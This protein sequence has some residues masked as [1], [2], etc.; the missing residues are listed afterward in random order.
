[1]VF[2]VIMYGWESEVK[3][4]VANSWPTLCN[5]MDCR[6]PGSSVHGIFQARILEW[7]AI[8]FSRRSSW[9]RDWTQVSCIVG[10]CFTIWATREVPGWESWAIKNAEHQRINAFKLWCWRRLLRVSWTA[11]RSNQ[12]ILRKSTLNIHWKDWC[13]S[14]SSSTLATCCKG[15]IHCKRPSCW[16]KLRAGGEGGNRGWDGWMT[17]STQWT[18]IWANSGR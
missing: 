10:R 16:E 9:P 7:V 15:Q 14:W 4:E 3:S 13:W 8:S 11:R 6:L 5:P 17:S 18:C 12:T 2:P 1:M